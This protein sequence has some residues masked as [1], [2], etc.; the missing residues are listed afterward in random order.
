M[1]VL[2]FPEL[3][4]SK[5][6]DKEQLFRHIMQAHLLDRKIVFTNGCYDIIHRG[7][8]ELLCKAAMLGDLMIVGLNSDLS[9]KS[10]K[11]SDRPVQDEMTR[12]MVLASMR[13]VDLVILFDEDTPYELIKFIQPDVLVKGGDYQIKDIAGSDIVEASGGK[14]VTIELLEGYSTTNILKKIC[15]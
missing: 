6:V 13:V 8:I 14:V 11:G 12:A 15:K 2:N 9:V 10:I 5:I 3:I 1:S 4:K 7:H